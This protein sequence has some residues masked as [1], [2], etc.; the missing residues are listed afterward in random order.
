MRRRRRIIA[1]NGADKGFAS[2]VLALS[3]FVMLL[4]FFIVL[5]SISTY[6]ES[7]ARSVLDSLEYAF[8]SKIT[9]RGDVRPSVTESVEQSIYDGDT[10]DRINALFQAQIPAYEATI[11]KKRG[12]MHIRVTRDDFETAV[13]ALGQR[14]APLG[15]TKDS[16]FKNYF[17]PTLVTMLRSG[18]RGQPFR[19][20]ITYN[21]Q[22][23]PARMQRLAPQ[24]LL[25]TARRANGMAEKIEKAGLPT[26]FIASAVQDGDPDFV[27]LYFIR[28]EKFDAARLLPL[29]AQYDADEAIDDAVETEGGSNGTAP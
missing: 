21:V 17:L 5:N 8:A 23:S 29:D 11:N 6:E 16:A 14:Q 22:G 10:I 18:D 13:N 24:T 28:Y 9:E 19:L 12:M 15:T 25:I 3:L 4:A 2:Q 1:D 20:E 7:K 26:Q 27:D